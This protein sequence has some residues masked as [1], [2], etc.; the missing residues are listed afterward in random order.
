VWGG[1]PR[2][3]LG[4][5]VAAFEVGFVAVPGADR[6]ITL[7]EAKANAKAA[8]EGARPTRHTYLIVIVSTC[9]PAT[10]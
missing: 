1:R 8:G 5:G 6:L 10:T 7:A 2:P 4:V 9:A 3:P